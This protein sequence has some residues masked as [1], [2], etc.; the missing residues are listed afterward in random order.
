MAGDSSHG[1]YYLCGGHA[2]EPGDTLPKWDQRFMKLAEQVATWS[3]DPSTQTGAVIVSPDRTDVILG[4]NGFARQMKDDTALYADRPTKYSRVIHCEVN[5]V[6]F[7]RRSVEGY[8]L[9]TAPFLSCDRCAVTMIQ[10]GIKRV[11]APMPTPDGASRWADMF[12]KS[13]SYFKEAGV[14]VIE[15]DRDTMIVQDTN[16]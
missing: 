5:A 8:T 7:A 9:Y 10:A 6:I 16:V 12:A 2:D 13:R 14:S 3:K 15:Y 4:Y 11:V 1:A